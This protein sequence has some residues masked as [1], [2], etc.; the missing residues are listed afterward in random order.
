MASKTLD[1]LVRA[2]MYK[3]LQWIYY[4]DA[5][6]LPLAQPLGGG[7]SMWYWVRGWCNLLY[8]SDYY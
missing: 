2:D 5:A 8:P 6:G 1:G 3:E 4:N 7:R